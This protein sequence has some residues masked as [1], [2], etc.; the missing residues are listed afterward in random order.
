VLAGL[1]GGAVVARTESGRLD[2]QDQIGAAVDGP[3]VGVEAE[4]H[5]VRR[6]VDLVAELL[7]ER[8]QGA[9][10]AVLERVGHG[11]QLDSV[12]HAQ[13]VAGRPCPSPTAA[14]QGHLERVVAGG[15]GG[16]GNIERAGH[17]GGPGQLRGTPEEVATR[18]GLAVAHGLVLLAAVVS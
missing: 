14:D 17:G 15:V 12:G 5:P 10:G 4:E 6:H 18:N 2:Q 7:F 13:A 9:A 11:D 8:A 3:L 1:D 16:A